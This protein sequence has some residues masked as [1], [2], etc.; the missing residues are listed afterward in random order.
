MQ[1]AKSDSKLELDRQPSP[2]EEANDFSTPDERAAQANHNRSLET[3]KLEQGPVGRIIG[4]SDSSLNISFILLILGF[5]TMAVLGVSLI[6]SEFA[7]G[8]FE[9]L[10]TFELTIAGYVMG[11]KSQ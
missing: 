4:S 10:I 3:L 2:S 7:K 5:L 6:W 8:L 1:M 11:K 9:K